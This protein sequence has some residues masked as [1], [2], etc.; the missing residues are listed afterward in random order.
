MV[1]QLADTYF[2]SYQLAYKLCK[3]VGALLPV[4]ARHP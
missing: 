3:Q 1:G 4:R 2:Q